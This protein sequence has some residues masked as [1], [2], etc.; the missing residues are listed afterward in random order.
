MFQEFRTLINIGRDYKPP[1]SYY[2]GVLLWKLGLRKYSKVKI[3]NK[4]FKVKYNITWPLLAYGWESQWRNFMETRVKR[5]DVVFDI[6]AHQGFHT[7]PLSQLAGRVVAFEPDPNAREVLVENLKMNSV[8]N[9]D[10][11][12]FAIMDYHGKTNLLLFG[13]SIATTKDRGG[14][15]P[16]ISVPC[17]TIDQFC[18]ENSIYPSGMKIDV[19]GAEDQVLRGAKETIQKMNPWILVEQ[20][21]YKTKESL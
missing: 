10:V 21:E 5:E 17:T 8:E 16:V 19:E 20:H 3:L 13:D 9:V 18:M 14:D 11:K 12:P 7:I 2:L 6:G 15:G 1:I 4:T